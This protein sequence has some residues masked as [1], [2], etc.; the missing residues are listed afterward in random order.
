MASLSSPS[1]SI[2]TLALGEQLACN[3]GPGQEYGLLE[4]AG[5]EGV[6]ALQLEEDEL[7]ANRFGHPGRLDRGQPHRDTFEIQAES[8]VF[9]TVRTCRGYETHNCPRGPGAVAEPLVLPRVV[10]PKRL[11]HPTD[12]HPDDVTDLHGF[13]HVPVEGDDL[14]GRVVR[15]QAPRRGQCQ[16][17]FCCSCSFSSRF[18]LSSHRGFRVVRHSVKA[19]AACWTSAHLRK[20]A[21]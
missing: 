17:G 4:E 11:A 12:G 6:R 21:K 7:L 9:L 19:A 18:G 20:S 16:M 3:L 14:H 15:G 1:A 10:Q 2:R 13:E 5:V 8:L